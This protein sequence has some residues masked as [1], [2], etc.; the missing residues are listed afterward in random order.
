[1][2]KLYYR[3]EELQDRYGLCS[4]DIRYLMERDQLPLCFFRTYCVFIA[5]KEDA[6]RFDAYGC[7]SYFGLVELKHYHNDALLENGYTDASNCYLL[8]KDTVETLSVDCPNSIKPPNNFISQWLHI[9]VE[10]LEFEQLFAIENNTA[11][12][13]ENA[14]GEPESGYFFPLKGQNASMHIDFP[15]HRYELKDLVITH[16]TLVELGLFTEEPK[17]KADKERSKNAFHRLIEHMIASHPRK[18]ASELWALLRNTWEE[19]DNIDPESILSE[20]NERSLVWVSASGT[21]NRISY[22]TFQN[23]VSEIRK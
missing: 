12:R 19:D 4:Y 20:V 5:G 3:L 15:S 21:E 7:V 18:R 6:H 14:T 23:R 1:M 17:A 8:E 11:T 22:K 2:K 10:E 16:K 13:I 9:D